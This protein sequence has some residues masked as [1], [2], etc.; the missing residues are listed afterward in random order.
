MLDGLK[1]LFSGSPPAPATGWEGIAPWAASRQYAFRGVQSEG[2]VID[3]RLG[4]AP[5]RL[6]WGPSQRPYIQGQELR[7]RAEMG[8]RSDLH[9]VLMNRELQETMEKAVFDQYVEGVQ[10]RIDN[11]TPPEM[12]WLVMF[13]KLSGAEMGPLRERYMAL[14]SMKGWLM[15]WLEGPLTE[16]LQ[17]LRVDAS[18]PTVLMIGRGRLMLRTT[19]AEP[20]VQALQVWLRLFEVAMREARR[21]ANDSIES[22]SPSTQPSLW[23][24]SALPG[25]E[26]KK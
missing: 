3:G 9:L 25:D 18:V 20:E 15:R 21:V 5:W 16:S 11:Q 22:I 12:R 14:S 19:L 23:S 26:R 4:V 17:A 7:L 8:L 1:R 6:E 13:P 24:G 2:F 10:T